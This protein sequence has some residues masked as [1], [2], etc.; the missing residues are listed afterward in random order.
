MGSGPYPLA[1]HNPLGGRCGHRGHFPDGK[2]GS[3]ELSSVPRAWGQKQFLLPEATH[4][5]HRPPPP[6]PHGSQRPRPWLGVQPHPCPWGRHHPVGL[7]PPPHCP[8]QHLPRPRASCFS[9]LCSQGLAPPS[10]VPGWRPP[11]QRTWGLSMKP[12]AGL[13]SSW[14]RKRHK[15]A[16]P[17]PWGGDIILSFWGTPHLVG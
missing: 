8:E 5:R 9:A 13:G 12:G 11:S 4:C 2:T 10:T 7:R 1:A 15:L 17:L 3:E 16:R 6:A 14:A